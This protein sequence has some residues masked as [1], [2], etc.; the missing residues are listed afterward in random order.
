MYIPLFKLID[1]AT[2]PERTTRVHELLYMSDRHYMLTAERPTK[3]FC[4]LDIWCDLLEAGPRYG[5][6]ETV[7]E[8][9]RVRPRFCGMNVYLVTGERNLMEVC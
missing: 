8:G 4:S 7:L 6:V 5:D 9:G 1:E 3:L 2:R